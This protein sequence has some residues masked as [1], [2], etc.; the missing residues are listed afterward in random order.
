M[1]KD[2]LLL[3]TGFTGALTLRFVWRMLSLLFVTSPSLR[4]HLATGTGSLDPLRNALKRAR[5]EV[6]VL[7]RS[8]CARPI[9]QALLDAEQRGVT[10]E[11]LID[12]ACE[13]DRASDVS[14]FLEQGFQPQ[15]S[16]AEVLGPEVILLIDGR[17]ILAG[18]FASPATEGDDSTINLMEIKGHP[19]V[20]EV[21][22]E[23]LKD[24]SCDA[25]PAEK[26]QPVQPTLKVHSSPADQV[27]S[28][29]PVQ[30]TPR[31]VP[32]P[33]AQP[34]RNLAPS[35][36]APT[37]PI[38]QMPVAPPTQSAPRVPTQ[39]PTSTPALARSTPAPAS[40]RSI[41][42]PARTTATP[43]PAPGSRPRV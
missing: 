35:A 43:A 38:P 2:C 11:L 15:V 20:F 25:R 22:R 31:S 29:L 34:Q 26:P 40:T 37:T 6:R 5:R 4:V 27:M 33:V 21:Y 32:G 3:A 14:F 41:P 30:P 16:A 9:A 24:H 8:F 23:L 17:T 39:T 42:T 1:W 13:R 19:E 18:G 28:N 7:A 36:P 12:A 10:V